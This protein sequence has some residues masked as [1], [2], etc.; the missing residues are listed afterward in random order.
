M[1][2]K[3]LN[4]I[5]KK[6]N[7]KKNDILETI[8]RELQNEI[9]DIKSENITGD[10]VD[11]ANTAYD[12]LVNSKLSEKEQEKLGEIRDALKRVEE[13]V[14]GRCVACGNNIEEKR[15]LAIPEAKKCIVCK[16]TEEKKNIL[17]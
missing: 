4:K 5:I 13:N 8:D 16:A 10:I 11:T 1:D 17:M 15:L 12:L 7:M 2:K 3:V 14:Y 6:L 9:D